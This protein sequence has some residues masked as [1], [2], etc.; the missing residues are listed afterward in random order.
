MSFIFSIAC[1]EIVFTGGTARVLPIRSF[2]SRIG[3]S[4]SETTPI[5]FF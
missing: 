5:G 1:T 2:G 4:S 3:F